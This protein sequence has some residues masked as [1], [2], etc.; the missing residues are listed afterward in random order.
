MQEGSIGLFVLVHL[1]S[2]CCHL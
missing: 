2:S 1:K